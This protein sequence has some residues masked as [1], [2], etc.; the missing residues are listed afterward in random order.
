MLD[1]WTTMSDSAIHCLSPPPGPTAVS[2]VTP[3]ISTLNEVMDRGVLVWVYRDCP[4]GDEE[5]EK[6][7]GW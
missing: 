7:Y 6:R 4:H 1:S 2:L 3:D 5:S